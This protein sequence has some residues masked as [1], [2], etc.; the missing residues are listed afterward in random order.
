MRDPYDLKIFELKLVAE[1]IKMA[2]DD[3][4]ALSINYQA[5]LP[6]SRRDFSKRCLF[7]ESLVKEDIKNFNSLR[8]TSLPKE[9]LSPDFKLN[10]EKKDKLVAS[11][12]LLI[13]TFQS[14]LSYAL[15]LEDDPY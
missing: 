5:K 15:S 14:N 9:G 3:L 2:I 12:N 7:L 11:I 6:G 13:K 8:L 1:N 10:L 4:V